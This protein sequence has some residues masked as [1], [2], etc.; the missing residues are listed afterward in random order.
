MMLNGLKYAQWLIVTL[1]G[2]PNLWVTST[3]LILTR[4]NLISFLT[5]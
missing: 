1:A 2:V 3:P 4:H 5:S